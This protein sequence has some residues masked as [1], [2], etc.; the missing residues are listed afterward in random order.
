MGLTPPRR[1]NIVAPDYCRHVLVAPSIVDNNPETMSTD[2]PAA[3]YNQRF[4]LLRAKDETAAWL[5]LAEM[6]LGFVSPK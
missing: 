2:P 3:S 6:I 1:R 5:V 4:V